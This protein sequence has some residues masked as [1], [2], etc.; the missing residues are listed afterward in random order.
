MNF[1]N[2][3]FLSLLCLVSCGPSLKKTM[4]FPNVNLNLAKIS[5]DNNLANTFLYID[6]I[7][8]KR[9]NHVLVRYEGKETLSTGEVSAQ[10]QELLKQALTKKGFS[11]SDTA[12][13]I[14]SGEI[15]KW[16]AEITGSLPSL[17][18]AESEFFIEI[19]DPANKRIYS[20]T[21][22]GKAQAEEGSVNDDDIRKVLSASLEEAVVQ[23]TSDKRLITLL[24]S[25]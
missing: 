4:D 14:I 18:V 13:V 21:Y 7:L 6:K 25:Y 23:F 9:N 1:K 22:S 19:L 10:L 17:I 12:P 11:F 16:Y 3:F 24:S 20:G 2:L 5:S 8:D 15:R